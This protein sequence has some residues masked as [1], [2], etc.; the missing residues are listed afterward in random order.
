MHLATLKQCIIQLL[1]QRLHNTTLTNP[2]DLDN[3]NVL[4][5]GEPYTVTMSMVI[6]VA[7]LPG[8]YNANSFV[9][10]AGPAPKT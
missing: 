3:N 8:D 5:E 9:D 2:A 4:D 10:A 7:S 1:Q 6:G